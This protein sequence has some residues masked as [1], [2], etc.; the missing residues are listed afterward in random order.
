[1]L[2][3]FVTQ[4]WQAVKSWRLDRN[5]YSV[6]PRRATVRLITVLFH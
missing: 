2:G 6:F 1:M 4:F 3:S 5:F